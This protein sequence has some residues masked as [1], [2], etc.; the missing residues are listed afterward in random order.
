ME[1]PPAIRSEDYGC[2][3]DQVA[4][5]LGRTG[6]NISRENSTH[7]VYFLGF[8]FDFFNLMYFTILVIFFWSCAVICNIVTVCFISWQ[9]SLHLKN[10]IIWRCHQ[11]MRRHPTPSSNSLSSSHVSHSNHTFSFFHCPQHGSRYSAPEVVSREQDRW[12]EVMGWG[13]VDRSDG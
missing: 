12:G 9:T 11:P 6:A 8:L 2:R 10:L 13:L 1:V 4:F 5:R 7:E 3:M